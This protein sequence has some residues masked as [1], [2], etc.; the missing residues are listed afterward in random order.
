M[1]Y[2]A[3]KRDPAPDLKINA[4]GTGQP[5]RDRVHIQFLHI[6]AAK[7]RMDQVF[8]AIVDHLPQ[9]L[10][11]RDAL[12]SILITDNFMDFICNEIRFEHLVIQIAEGGCKNPVAHQL[13][14]LGLTH[15]LNVL[16]G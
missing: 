15:L 1:V 14:V 11:V 12:D 9:R 8:P 2:A 4:R 10:P 7:I 5:L 16:Y 13:A 3:C 6:L